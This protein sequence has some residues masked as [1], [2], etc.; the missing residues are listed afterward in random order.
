MGKQSA[1]MFFN[2][3][4]HKEIYMNR[5]YHCQMHKGDKLLW[6]KLEEEEP[7]EPLDY[8]SM[9]VTDYMADYQTGEKIPEL[10]P[11]YVGFTISDYYD[12]PCIIDWGDGT[13]T[14]GESEHI[15]P[16]NNGT[17]YTVKISGG[18]YSFAGY[19]I[20][21]DSQ[22]IAS[23][24]TEILTPLLRCMSVNKYDESAGEV[25]IL[26]AMFAWAPLLRKI[27]QNLFRNMRDFENVSAN[28]FL[29]YSA[30][31]DVPTGLFS[32]IKNWNLDGF[33]ASCNQIMTVPKNTF[34]NY[35]D[36][37]YGSPPF[38]NCNGL[39]FVYD[40]PPKGVAFRNCP[41]L[42]VVDCE[43][44]GLTSASG[45]F[46]GLSKLTHVGKYLFRDCP[47]LTYFAKCF[48]NCSSLVEIPENLFEG[49]EA[50][51][52]QECFSGCSSLKAIPSDIF[53][54]S[55]V[56]NNFS[57][58]FYKCTS[59]ESIPSDLFE[60]VGQGTNFGYAFAFTNISS[61]PMNLFNGCAVN[62]NFQNTFMGCEHITSQVPDLWNYGDNGYDC[63][64]GCYNAANYDAIPTKWK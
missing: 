43:F 19:K 8:F 16:T 38:L 50:T 28:S 40:S 37:S 22:N 21:N 10:T 34:A 59:L 33:F 4:D 31:S 13:I 3:K 49:L 54:D 44:H 57:Y 39:R 47:E 51:S 55:D 5:N 23:C 60:S 46:S 9:R 58:C 1:R 42:E 63:Y 27:P 48:Y 24:V 6:E 62:S 12:N 30:I 11:G 35:T 53:K 41:N 7:Y 15:Y 56:A 32:G 61:I 45:L 14:Q 29:E 36:D 64:S 20:V 52:F 17:E 26:S 2:G 25:P 18:I